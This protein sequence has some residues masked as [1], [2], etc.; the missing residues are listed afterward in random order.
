MLLLESPSTANTIMLFS[1][2][3]NTYAVGS[4]SWMSCLASTI[5]CLLLCVNL[6]PIR[7]LSMCPCYVA[8]DGGRSVLMRLYVRP[9]K[10]LN[11]LGWS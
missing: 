1:V 8:I 9:G 3:V 2:A 7:V 5:A 6:T 4:M 11:W 10:L